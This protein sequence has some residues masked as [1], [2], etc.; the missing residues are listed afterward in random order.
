[1]N[2]EPTFWNTFGNVTMDHRTK[3][4]ISHQFIGRLL[5]GW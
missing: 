4:V 2:Y 3:M 1:M 5:D